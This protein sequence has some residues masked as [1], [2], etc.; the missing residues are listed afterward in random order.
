[1]RIN[2]N[3]TCRKEEKSETS[4]CHWNKEQGGTT[5][6]VNMSPI[7]FFKIL[8]CMQDKMGRVIQSITQQLLVGGIYYIKQKTTC[9]GQ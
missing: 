9:F 1:M 8:L 7:Y 4:I 3:T 5:F 6:S 2:M